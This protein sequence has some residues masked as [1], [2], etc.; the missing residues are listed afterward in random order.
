M[1]MVPTSLV[2]ILQQ[3]AKNQPDRLAFRFLEDGELGETVLTYKVLDQRAR[4]IGA[5]L[6]SV[7]KEGDRALLF[8]PPGLHFIAAFFGCL[9]A[10]VIAV[11]VYPPHPARLEK[12]LPA[13][14]RIIADSKPTA[15]LLTASLF[16]S[17]GAERSFRTELDSIRLLVTD[18]NEINAGINHWQEPEIEGHDLAFLQYTS[19][20]TTMPKGVMVSHNNLLHNLA[21]IE[22]SFGQSTDSHAV[23]WLP[24]Y[25][26]MG[27][28]GGILQ[29][30][31]SGF[32][33][34]LL[35]HLLFLQRP[36]R[37]LEVISRFK[38]TTSGGPNFAYDLCLRKIKPEQRD[39]LDLR[40]WEVAFNGAEPVQAKTLDQFA[41][42]FAPC[43]F[44]RE[45]FLP[46]YGLAEATLLVSGG[47]AGR[48]VVQQHLSNSGLVQHKV[49]LSTEKTAD[50]RTV[51]GCGLNL[52]G[53]TI[54]I[55]NPDTGVSCPPD[56]IGEIWIGG[57]SVAR[58]YWNN[59]AETSFT[60]NAWLSNGEEG[61]F[62][63]TGD[64][65][66]VKDGELYITGRL[67]NLLIS[68]GKNH[69]PHDLE[70]TVEN[71]H[72]A[73]L[74]EGSA[75]FGMNESPE[76]IVVVAEIKP[77]PDVKKEDVVKAIRSAVS[78]HHGLHVDDIR[79]TNPG[80]IP[81]TTSGKKKHFLCREHYL[82]GTLKEIH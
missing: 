1:T 22:K 15:A 58:G 17:I 70:R 27:L 14:L 13:V 48:P 31:Y 35:P 80:E 73:I 69:Y 2:D 61:P 19:G 21:L 20:S 3:R 51:V 53:Q 75:V 57:E 63:R 24:P 78:V 49:T 10:K 65:G 32:P 4:A 16:H 26:D 52:S 47:P 36:F 59:A 38:A 50:T 37:W 64:L 54:R 45:A 39:L 41:A 5:L 77:K 18:N 79:L 81:K 56:E 66:F 42:Y 76:R 43:G 67:K 46:C 55:V 11:P 82:T 12:T 28:I 40:S 6:Q 68:E 30:L 71:S 8:F 25:H 9:Y 34:T 29:P 72:P 60:F 23:I 62:L 74:P 7:T 33:A 44:K